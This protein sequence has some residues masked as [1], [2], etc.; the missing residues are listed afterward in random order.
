MTLSPQSSDAPAFSGNLDGAIGEFRNIVGT[1]FVHAGAATARHT[2]ST[3]GVERR[4]PAVVLPASE[5]EVI[6]IVRAAARY[7]TPLYP[8][9]TGRNWGYGCAAPVRDGCIVV[10]LSR[11]KRLSVDRRFG[12]ATLEPGVTQ[13]QLWEHLRETN[14]PFMV[15]A[16][17]AGPMTSIVGNALERGYGVTPYADHFGAVTS[18][19][20]ILPN[21]E[22]FRPA[23]AELGGEVTD[24]SHKWGVGP[25]LDGLFSQGSF[26]I[27]TE[28]T[29]TLARR[30][31]VVEAFIFEVDSESAVAPIVNA[32][33]EVLQT[34][35][36]AIGAI[37]LLNRR[38]LLSMTAPY[39]T[40]RQR[41][42][43]L[44]EDCVDGL[45]TQLGLPRWLGLGGIYGDAGVVRAV[46]RLI[47]RHLAPHCRR[48]SFFS[49][50][51]AAL[52]T[53]LARLI[54][55]RLGQRLQLRADKLSE[56][57]DI[58][59][60]R[61]RETALQLA[62][63]K[64]GISP[65]PGLTLDPSRDGCGLI[66]YAPLVPMVPEAVR[67]F[68]DL[69]EKTCPRFG[70]EPLITLTSVSQ[71]A[72]DSTV[73]ILFDLANDASA[74]QDCY[75]CLLH[76]GRRRGFVP[77]R[78]GTHAMDFYSERQDS[79]YWHVADS[80]K[81]ALDPDG[82]ISPGRYSRTPDAP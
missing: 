31:A 74:A 13:N 34:S 69:V 16:T 29:I 58:L 75:E 37:N 54:P 51:R 12:T 25:Y 59:A 4:V 26:G 46:R 5:K 42:T 77:Y 76:E 61:P 81:R 10:E 68:V 53:G 17:G 33:R 57:L 18:L 64:S 56:L 44:P 65:T 32:I 48:L 52:A 55:G 80:V 62:Y 70:V 73:P 24:R 72:F 27:V 20:A 82:I 2:R 38:R 35:G 19:T 36:G 45:A 3:I 40:G 43:V 71:G 41:G 15:P 78:L 79:P 50:N 49:E 14:L 7:R 66:W 60:G 47:R 39:P 67:E 30:P 1:D 8:I 6:E 11:M 63:W 23:L 28:M 21:G 9:S 22:R